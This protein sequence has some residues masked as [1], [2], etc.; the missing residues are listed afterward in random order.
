MT[1]GSKK[2]FERA[3]PGSFVREVSFCRLFSLGLFLF[4]KRRSE[5]KITPNKKTER[6]NRLDLIL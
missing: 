3:R 1:R 4:T 5:K 6:K 2:E